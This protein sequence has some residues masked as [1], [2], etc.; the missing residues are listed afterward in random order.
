LILQVL[1]R[2]GS[3]TASSSNS[4][5]VYKDQGEP[6]WKLDDFSEPTST[7]WLKSAILL[8][9][10]ARDMLRNVCHCQI[11][12]WNRHS[13]RKD[14]ILQFRQRITNLEV[15]WALVRKA[16]LIETRLPARVMLERQIA[17][18]RHVI[19]TCHNRIWQRRWE[20]QTRGGSSCLSVQ[21]HA[22]N[23]R[24]R[25]VRLVTGHHAE[26]YQT[27]NPHSVVIVRMLGDRGAIPTFRESP[28]YSF[29][30]RYPKI[31]QQLPR[32][33]LLHAWTLYPPYVNI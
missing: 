19:W 29:N 13:C 8:Q 22:G 12:C 18:L 2:S 33:W 15:A 26:G 25:K 11:G 24:Q 28:C 5:A 32:K 31:L 4:Q 3:K 1:D 27:V 21:N 23:M 14:G 17:T 20:C 9:A 7:L 6:A 16:Q 10:K 30:S